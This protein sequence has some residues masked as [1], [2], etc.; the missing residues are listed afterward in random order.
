MRRE[1]DEA[2]LMRMKKEFDGASS[3]LSRK[4]G[5]LDSLL[6]RMKEAFGVEEMARAERILTKK[7]RDLKGMDEKY[8]KKLDEVKKAYEQLRA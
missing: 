5:E 7:K 2:K 3:S 6:K 1:S 4:E 8:I